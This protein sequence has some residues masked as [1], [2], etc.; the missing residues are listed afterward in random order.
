MAQP[1]YT[2]DPVTQTY[3]LVPPEQ[4]PVAGLGSLYRLDENG[5]DSVAPSGGKPLGQGINSTLQDLAFF[6]QAYSQ[7]LGGFLPGATL[8]GMAS[9]AA[10]DQQRDA[11][12]E[13]QSNLAAMDAGPGRSMGIATVSDPVG[14]T[15]SM[16]SP[17]TV[18]AADMNTFG[19][20]AAQNAAAGLA[21]MNAQNAAEQQAQSQQAAVANTAA[22]VAQSMG[23]SVDEAA[24]AAQDAANAADAAAAGGGGNGNGGDGGGGGGGTAGV[25]NESE[26]GADGNNSGG[27]GDPDGNGTGEGGGWYRGGRIPTYNQGGIASLANKVQSQGR[28]QDK[29]LVHMT[30]KEVAGLQALAMQHGG[31][32][33]INPRTGLVEAGFLSSI[34]PM[35]AGAALAATGVGAPLAAG[36]VGGASYLMNPKQGLMGGLMAGLSAYG[37]AGLGTALAGPGSIGST[38]METAAMENVYMDPATKVMR[39]EFAAMGQ[40]AQADAILN[41]QKAAAE[42]YAQQGVMD[43]LSQSASAIAKQPFDVTVN[44]LGGP[45]AALKTVGPAVATTALAAAGTGEEDQGKPPYEAKIRPFSYDPGRKTAEPD[46]RYRTGERG[47]STAEQT[48][49]APRYTPLGVYKPGQEPTYGTYSGGGIT[50]LKHGGMEEGGYVVAA[51]VVSHLGN[52]STKAGQKLLNRKL[53]GVPLNGSGDGM[54]DDIKTHIEGKQPARVADGEVYIPASVAKGRAKDLDRMMK[55]IRKAKTGRSSQAPE[56]N[57]SKFIPA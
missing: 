34:L 22:S 38:A 29:V 12:A 51:D 24:D 11:M 50:A 4:A 48:Y 36:L 30:P 52:G 1:Q 45:M 54:S 27:G 25:G 7:A 49:F 33:T 46:F 9:N 31:S 43:R 32:L 39:P 35:V 47:E 53:G 10:L 21:A 16:S 23:V 14:N 15:F 17:A 55:R 26:H 19:T 37:G 8:I 2:Y 6:G 42:Q 28:G 41:A 44:Q 57:T 20:T 18:D 5:A 56:M 13:A 40:Q 3:T